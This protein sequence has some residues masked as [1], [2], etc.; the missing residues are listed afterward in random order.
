MSYGMMCACVRVCACMVIWILFVIGI[1]TVG[2]LTVGILTVYERKYHVGIELHI[3][4]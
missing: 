2:I 4:T 1:L 3:C